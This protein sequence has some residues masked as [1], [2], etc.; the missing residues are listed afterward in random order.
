VGVVA[1]LA[2]VLGFL[3]SANPSPNVGV[4]N[5]ENPYDNVLHLVVAVWA[6]AAA[7]MKPK[8]GMMTNNTPPATPPNTTGM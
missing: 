1:L 3:N 4:A 7:F 6:F 8:G 2:A 5:L